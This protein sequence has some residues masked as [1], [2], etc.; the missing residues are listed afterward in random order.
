VESVEDAVPSKFTLSQNYPNPF[1][2]TTTISFSILRDAN[3]TLTVYNLLGQKVATLVDES[4]TPGSYLIDFDAR[5]LATGT[6]FYAIE[7]GSFKSVKKMT[8]LK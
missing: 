4:L 5:G 6:Y 8:L 1:N 3:V 2:P 7:A